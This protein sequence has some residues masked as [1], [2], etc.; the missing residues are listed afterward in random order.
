M[1]AS[2][3]S[4]WHPLL[5]CA[6][7]AGAGAE[8][9]TVC[10][11]VNLD[12][13]TSP[14]WPFQGYSVLCIGDRAASCSGG[15]SADDE[16][17]CLADS[18]LHVTIYNA[19]VRSSRANLQIPVPA[20]LQD[21][22]KVLAKEYPPSNPTRH[23]KIK[24][25]FQKKGR[26]KALFAFYKPGR[27]GELPV[28]ISS[29]DV[30]GLTGP[31]LVYEGGAF[32]WPGIEIDFKRNVSLNMPGTP[33]VSVTLLTRSLQPL[34]IEVSSFL[35]KSECQHII[36]KAEPRMAKSG[37]SHMDHDVG[38]ADATW[39]TSSTYFMPSDTDIVKRLDKRVAALTLQSVRHQ[40]YAQVLRYEKNEHYEAHHDFFDVAL[41]QKSEQVLGLTKN[42]LFNRLA[43][44][45][46][47]LSTVEKGGQTNFPRAGGGPQPRNFAA[48][49]EGVS[50]D[51][52]EGRIIIFYSLHPSGRTDEY[53]LHGG[54][55]VHEG[56]KWSANKW[57]WNKPMDYLRE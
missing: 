17:T 9:S 32:L 57:I 33:P 28:R 22:E 51:P 43:T 49:S 7:L 19:G 13:W 6:L 16:A 52:Q 5:L 25:A 42:G 39:R 36:G 15:A 34:V 21:L 46:F 12:D 44:V 4:I 26:D 11:D 20:D 29:T 54:C 23:N 27:A 50:I 8:V 56:T 47:Y 35:D 18:S 3:N 2:F 55:D 37:V 53:S 48:C 40:E 31:V 24:D 41:Y 10:G 30:K 14:S 38:K 45:F 1:R